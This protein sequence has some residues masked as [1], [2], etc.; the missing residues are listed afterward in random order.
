MKF[1][2]AIAALILAATVTATALPNADARCGYPGQPC[3]KVKAR[4]A[5]PE[6]DARCGYPGQPCGKAKRDAMPDADAR[7][8]YPGQPCGKVKRAAEAFAEALVP[9]PGHI[10]PRDLHLTARCDMGSCYEAK[11]MTRDLA[12]IVA[13]T[14]EDPAAYY[15]SLGLEDEETSEKLKR[16]AS[17]RCGYPGQ[18]CGKVKRDAAPEPEADARCGYPGQ[19]CGKAKREADPE[20]DARCGYPGQPCGKLKRAAEAVAAAIAEAEPA[21]RC[22]YP[23]QP[24]GKAKRDA[25]ALAHAVD[26]VLGNL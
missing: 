19:P 4:L 11:R 23:G 9:K 3:G 21:A 24:C 13:E 1:T 20:A 2:A 18:P 6:A 26:L 10:L 17:A 5:E 25:F 7:C 8:G 14:T 12:A 22:G 15:V 16:E